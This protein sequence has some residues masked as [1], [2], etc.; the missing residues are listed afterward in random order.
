MAAMVATEVDITAAYNAYFLF[1]PKA[2]TTKQ[3]AL[4]KKATRNTCSKA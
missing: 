3:A 4:N 1:Q 2:Y